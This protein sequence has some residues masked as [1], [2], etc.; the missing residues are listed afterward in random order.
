MSLNL[1]KMLN[2]KK[3]IIERYISQL[4]SAFFKQL[5]FTVPYVLKCKIIF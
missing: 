1:K 2:L 3:N 5:E 4:A